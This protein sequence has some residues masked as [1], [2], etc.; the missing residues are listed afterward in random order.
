MA[1]SASPFNG[2]Y[3]VLL[4]FIRSKEIGR[5]LNKKK[6]GLLRVLVRIASIGAEMERSKIVAQQKSRGRRPAFPF[7]DQSG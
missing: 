2:D 6:N 7:H 4:P 3:F 1:D 5:L